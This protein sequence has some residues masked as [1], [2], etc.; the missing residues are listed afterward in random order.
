MLKSV[1]A[2]IGALVVGWAIAGSATEASAY[3][4][5]HGC[6]GPIPPSY[7]YHTKKVHKNVFHKHDVYRTKYVKRIHRI[8]HVTRIKPIVHVYNVT[9][10]HTNI[11]GVVHNKYEHHTQWLPAKKIVTN[12]VVHLRPHCGCGGG[13]HHYGY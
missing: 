3:H 6:C 4:R 10:V 1:S 13:H 11:V 8:V 2:L 7:Y 9:R 12:R 5:H